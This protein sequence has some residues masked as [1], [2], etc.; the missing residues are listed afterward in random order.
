MLPLVMVLGVFR[1]RS[2][3]V[4]SGT[5]ITG[6]ELYRIGYQ[7]REGHN[8]KIREMGAYPLN[9]AEMLMILSLGQL[10]YSRRFVGLL[11]NRKF[12]KKYFMDKSQVK[13]ME[14]KKEIEDD[15]LG[16]L[17][18]WRL[19]RSMLP[20][21]PKVLGKSNLPT[22]MGQVGQISPNQIPNIPA[23]L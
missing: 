21:H 22:K 8:S 7:S 3:L 12:Y 18:H 10:F 9:I 13:L 16:A 14:V 17:K 6:R 2:T 19:N 11:K 4:L 5:V 23:H 1:P 20:M 15:K